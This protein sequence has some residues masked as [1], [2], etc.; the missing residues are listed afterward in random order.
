MNAGEQSCSGKNRL[1]SPVCVKPG[2]L[3]SGRFPQLDGIALRIV[4][5]RKPADPH[6]IPFFLGNHFDPGGAE[7][8]EKAVDVGD[9]QI[10]HR[11]AIGRE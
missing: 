1:K 2:T 9:A 11:S 4:D 5:S 10:D 8:G 6:G 7:L 3:G